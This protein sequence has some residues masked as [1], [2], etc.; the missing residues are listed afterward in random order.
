M[1]RRALVSLALAVA[2]FLYFSFG[3]EYPASMSIVMGLAVG[4]LAYA[5]QRTGD[6]LRDL[7]RR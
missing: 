2:G 1:R 3:R 6:H 7:Y 4:A 5:V